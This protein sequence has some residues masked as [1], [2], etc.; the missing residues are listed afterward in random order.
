MHALST[1]IV[2][3]TIA[4][5][6]QTHLFTRIPLFKPPAA[7]LAPTKKQSI[8]NFLKFCLTNKPVFLEKPA[9]SWLHT[10][11][12]INNDRIIPMRPLKTLFLLSSVAL[13]R[14]LGNMLGNPSSGIY[15]NARQ[16]D[17]PRGFSKSLVVYDGIDVP[18]SD[19]PISPFGI[20]WRQI[21]LNF[22]SNNTAQIL[23]K[24]I[25]GRHQVKNNAESE[26][27]KDKLK[28]EKLKKKYEALEKEKR[29][30][31]KQEKERSDAKSLAGLWKT[32]CQ[33]ISASYQRISPYVGD[34]YNLLGIA[35]VATGV[36]GLIK[37]VTAY[38]GNNRQV[39]QVP[40]NTGQPPSR[41]D[42]FNTSVSQSTEESDLDR[43]IR[44]L[45]SRGGEIDSYLLGL[46]KDEISCFSG[47]MID[48]PVVS[49]CKLLRLFDYNLHSSLTC[50]YGNENLN[51]IKYTVIDRYT[52]QLSSAL[53]TTRIP[54]AEQITLNQ[55]L[56]NNR[57]R[58]LTF[59][60]RQITNAF[61]TLN[62]LDGNGYIQ[63]DAHPQSEI[64]KDT[65]LSSFRDT[66]N[67]VL[68]TAALFEATSTEHEHLGEPVRSIHKLTI[69]IKHIVDQKIEEGNRIVNAYE[70]LTELNRIQTD[71]N[72]PSGVYKKYNT[73]STRDMNEKTDQ[74][75]KL[76]L[77][78]ANYY[79][80]N[81]SIV[82]RINAT[83]VNM[84][85]V[86]QARAGTQSPEQRQGGVSTADLN[87][88][89]SLISSP[90]G[91]S[92]TSSSAGGRG[93]IVARVGIFDN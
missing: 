83:L 40:A 10:L 51:G 68:S 52:A 39:G 84:E 91:V 3:T 48:H 58:I 62:Y 38:L 74:I 89:N 43:R 15:V 64:S 14:Q 59:Y 86:L 63:D 77:E 47:G 33:W 1:V 21:R 41:S 71:L 29:K 50:D 92:T 56:N 37:Y 23:R 54:S 9:F 31:E 66:H 60:T 85:S 19:R 72:Q 24:E 36:T 11:Q 7:I 80:D 69:D 81:N 12:E 55:W 75:N 45:I 90:G 70:A 82:S 73:L 67:Y 78:L 35:V 46:F 16:K 76:V 6:R 18:L 87:R 27:F 26:Q 42:Q 20:L 61:N 5:L 53:V 65:I 88:H 8:F 93:K 79:P 25:E 13:V 57:T 28:H 44:N 34:V 17:S 49:F 32:F 30:H 22:V 2:I 4:I